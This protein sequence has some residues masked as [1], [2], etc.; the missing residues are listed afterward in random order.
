MK[1][2]L[3][4]LIAAIPMCYQA[5]DLEQR[6]IPGFLQVCSEELQGME[7]QVGK[8][9]WWAA[10]VLHAKRNHP[11]YC[12]FGLQV[13]SLQDKQVIMYS[14]RS[15]EGIIIKDSISYGLHSSTSASR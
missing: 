6:P 11:G 10:L 9:E 4:I 5:S 7:K 2:L 15:P 13:V 12:L 14:V 1:K 8:E 3:L